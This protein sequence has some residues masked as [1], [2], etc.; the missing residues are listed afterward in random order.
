MIR[1]PPACLIVIAL[2]TS[3]P[4]FGTIVPIGAITYDNVVPGTATSPGIDGFS[5]ANLTGDPSMGGWAIP[6]DF[7][8]LTGVTL[9]NP[10]LTLLSPGSIQVV[11]LPNIG[12]GFATPAQLYFLDGTP[13]LSATLTASLSTTALTLYDGSTF[14]AGSP[15][16]TTTMSPL[17]GTTLMPGVDSALISL[18]DTP[19]APPVFDL[20][21]WGFRVNGVPFYNGGGTPQPSDIDTG[22]FDFTTG[23]GTV[24]ITDTPGVA[25]TYS[26]SSYENVIIDEDL[27]TAWDAVGYNSGPA[28]AGV[29]WQIGDPNAM[30]SS[31]D[32]NGNCIPNPDYI[33]TD[34]DSDSLEDI[35]YSTALGDVA[36]AL[37][38][39]FT[40]GASD[41][42]VV[43]FTISQ[44]PPT[45]GFYLQ[46]IDPESPANVY[47]QVSLQVI[48]GSSSIPE[49]STFGLIGGSIGL[50]WLWRRF[51]S[52]GGS[53]RSWRPSGPWVLLP[54]LLAGAALFCHPAFAVM[55]TV[56]IVPAV[57]GS[58][59]IPHDT[60]SGRTITLKG[61]TS[62]QGSNFQWTWDFGD[63]SPLATGTVTNQYAVGATHAYTGVPGQVFTASLTVQDLTTGEQA[64]GFYYAEIRTESLQIE[65]NVAIDEGLWYL[66]ATQE[67]ITSGLTNY[68]YWW[69]SSYGYASYG[70]YAVTAA[71][72]NAFEV[73]GHLESGDPSDPYV[74]TVQRGL[75]SIFS[76]IVTGAIAPVTN[77]KGTFTPD[78]NGNGYAAYVNQDHAF[79]QGAMFIDAIVASGTPNAIT[80]TG[81]ASNGGTDPGVIGRTYKDVV[82]DLVDGYLYCQ[83]TGTAGGGWRYNCGDAPD[84][85]ACQWAAIGLISA[86]RGFGVVTPPI[87]EQWN[88]VWLATDQDPTN[89]EFG[90]T[91]AD[92]YPWGPYATTPS[93]LVQLAMD[94]IGRGDSRWDSAETFLCN[95]FGNS[96]SLGS[97]SSLRAYYYGMFSFVKAMLLHNPGGVPQ[98]ITML[99]SLTPGVA[100]IDWY[101]SDTRNGAPVDGVARTLTTQQN[102]AGFWYGNDYESP[103]YY[104]DTAFAIMM[105]NRTIFQSGSPV[106]VATANPNPVASGGT[107]AF[108]GSGSFQQDST[109]QIVAWAWDFTGGTNFTASGPQVSFTF[110]Q[111]IGN[112]PVRLRVTDNST[113]PQTA[114][115][116][117]I[118]VV[119]TPPMPPT[120][121]AGGPYS[122]CPQRTPWFL[123]GTQSQDPNNGLHDAGGIPD[124]IISYQWDFN[125][126]N[127]FTDATGPQPNVTSAFS[128]RIG[129]SFFVSLKVTDNTALAFPTS[130]L[131]D[132]TSVASTQ[133]TVHNST[134]TACTQ[135][136]NSLKAG[137]IIAVPGT[138]ARV[139]L[140][141]STV[142]ADHYNVYRGLVN[143]GP[144]SLIATVKSA[145]PLVVYVDTNVVVGKTYYW[146]VRP[147]G[148]NGVEIC[149]SNQASGLILGR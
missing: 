75:K 108:N 95:N 112:Y 123:D 89:G 139:D 131:P 18:S 101:G 128:S 142:G 82:S 3:A 135:C 62:V 117:V 113:P 27:Y 20:N 63:G 127:T 11:Q 110:N 102:A 130:G 129:T 1:I 83:Y 6:P 94:G 14:N 109:R 34:F 57:S 40:L 119:A 136:V 30:C 116:L 33:F 74:D 50:L 122:L 15:T 145:N 91:Q 85:S 43:T 69:T 38:Q 100:P 2:L 9:L 8:S 39:Q 87:V 96:V 47:E 137:V 124:S 41:T 149:Q 79:Y 146:V 104:L 97:P 44:T 141:W 80:T 147:A 121:N 12:P 111:P 59:L 23:L 114:D 92:Y 81:P 45:G 143:G 103:Q 29:S 48:P 5:I 21:D 46:E 88:L 132:L 77:G 58:P 13:F 138:P 53:A 31:F 64:H 36:W 49:P 71:N 72:V 65:A 134:D 35:N 68:G 118:V 140:S 55:P 98:P 106:A 148:A 144:Y 10:Q 76:W 107:V 120:A 99:Q 73:N 84:N 4:C 60:W 24:T 90:Y 25:G 17:N 115:T 56:K 16:L 86:Q 66:Q 7:P 133:V 78:T 105:L 19:V 61:T 70:Y 32:V 126:Q 22:N 93:G 125:G 54:I 42:A 37:G 52:D 26:V 67:R 28:P 51:K